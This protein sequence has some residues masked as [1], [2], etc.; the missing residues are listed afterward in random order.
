MAER[1]IRLVANTWTDLAS[2]LA[3][4][5]MGNHLILRAA[6]SD[7][8]IAVKAAAAPTVA[9]TPM[10]RNAAVEVIFG[11]NSGS[12]VWVRSVAGGYLGIDDIDGKTVVVV[13]SVAV[14]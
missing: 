12:K 1:R 14:A 10:P 5:D 11:F 3:P 2:I 13:P 7:F 9:G 4:A 6:G 8:E